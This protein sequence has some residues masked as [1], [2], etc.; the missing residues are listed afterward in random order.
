MSEAGVEVRTGRK[1]R[2]Q[3]AVRGGKVQAEAQFAGGGGN[4][5]KRAGLDSIPTPCYDQAKGK[6]R[7]KKEQRE[8]CALVEELNPV[9]Q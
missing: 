2:E 7:R 4:P 3:E 1:W 5:R 6:D 8:V 9:R